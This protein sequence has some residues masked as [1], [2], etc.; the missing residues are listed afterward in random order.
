MENLI[1]SVRAHGGGLASMG[2]RIQRGGE[3]RGE[4]MLQ[5]GRDGQSNSA[6]RQGCESENETFCRIS[7]T[8]YP[9]CPPSRREKG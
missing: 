9:L 6:Q 2:R 5:G 7:R 3:G 1:R 8:S 4:G